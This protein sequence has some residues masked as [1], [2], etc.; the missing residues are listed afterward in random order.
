MLI[1]GLTGGIGSGK[2]LITNIF[3][4]IGIPVYNADLNAK[5]LYSNAEIA[6][7]LCKMFSS[8]ILVNGKIDTKRLASIVFNDKAE[9]EK[10]NSFV[11][12][13]VHNDFLSWI[14]YQNS[15]YVIMESALIYESGW[16][17]DFDK[18]ICIDTPQD[19]SIQ[20]VII[21]DNITKEQVEKK[22]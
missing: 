4:N 5:K 17:T 22:N 9:L 12:P 14:K 18:I 10:L 11:H 15:A 20:R 6:K 7:K 13:L 21:R 3:Q 8:D 2:T 16:N 19:L 1:V